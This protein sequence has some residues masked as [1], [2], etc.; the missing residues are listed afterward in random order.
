MAEEETRGVSGSLLLSMLRRLMVTM[1]G[2]FVLGFGLFTKRLLPPHFAAVAAKTY[3]YPTLPLTYARLALL[4][5]RAGLWT[6]VDDTVLVGAAPCAML[7]HP[8]RL[9]D[10][11]VQGVVNLCAEY[12]GPSD[13]FEKLGIE[14]L[15]LPTVDHVEPSTEDLATAVDFIGRIQRQGGKVYVHCKAGHGRSAAVA[16][17]WLLKSNYG[18]VAPF[19]SYEA[20]ASKRGVRRNLWRQPNLLSYY[21][22][23][24]T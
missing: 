18:K 3:F 9:R 1:A 5:P 11:G 20:L 19:E 24:S 22:G 2:G 15:R 12:A 10:L 13:A 21:E 16:Y 4:P 8:R 17:A 23:F 6:A 7:G 14:Q